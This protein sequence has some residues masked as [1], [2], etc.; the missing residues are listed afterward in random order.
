MR[1]LPLITALALTMAACSQEP[2]PPTPESQ[3]NNAAASAPNGVGSQREV[4]GRSP[5]EGP[6]ATTTTPPSATAE[7]QSR[8]ANRTA[9]SRSGA[10]QQGITITSPDQR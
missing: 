9:T 4:N 3:S 8:D 10:D 5:N 2:P 6:A 1:S 7:Q